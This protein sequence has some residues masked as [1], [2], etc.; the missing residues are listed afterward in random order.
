M[1]FALFI[2]ELQTRFGGRWLGAFWVLL[3]PL[4]HLTLLMLVF[5]YVRNRVLPGIEFPVFLL[6][7]LLPFLTFRSLALRLMESVDAN[8]PLFSYRQVK[9]LDPLISRALL[10]IGLYGTIYLILLVTLGWLGYSTVPTRPLE[11]M[12]IS[13][14]LLVLGFALGL[15]FAVG[16]DELPRVRPFIRIAFMPLYLLSGVIFPVSALPAFVLPWVLWNPVLHAVE[17]SRGYF[18][19]HYRTLPQV[20][21][22]YVIVWG[23]AALAVGVSLYRVRRHRLLAS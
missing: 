7:G 4:A 3:E 23:V 19:P 22:L 20:S 5:G 6:T 1:L 13:I 21:A 14:A 10:E 9:P 8:R 18:F 16:T 17:I 11:L 15:I 12:A 2:R